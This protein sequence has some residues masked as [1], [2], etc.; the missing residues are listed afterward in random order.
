MRAFVLVRYGKGQML[1]LSELPTPSPRDDEVLVEVHAASI[2]LVGLTA[3]LRKGQK[4]FIQA[5][6][7]GVG[8]FAIQLDIHLGP[9]W[10]RR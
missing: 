8:S 9:R 5:G 7:G 4:V 6:F 3:R 1:Q 10:G 2:P